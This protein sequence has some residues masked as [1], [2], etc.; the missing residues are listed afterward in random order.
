M[1]D[2]E[3]KDNGDN[4]R[5]Q[6]GSIEVADG[7]QQN[8]Y[9]EDLVEEQRILARKI[10]KLSQDMEKFNLAGYINL[11]NNPKRFLGINFAGGV[12]RGLG[13]ALGAT[14]FA[15]L[16]IYLLQRL[17]VLNLPL[18]GDFLAEL[19]RIVQNHL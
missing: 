2:Q 12:A 15:A 4:R 18:V 13:F 16:V 6:A 5:S 14:V 17:L 1:N 8:D 9:P 10:Q 7:K 3:Q 11:V 19:I